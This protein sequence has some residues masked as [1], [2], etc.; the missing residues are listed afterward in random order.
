[1]ATLS[2]LVEESAAK[3]AQESIQGRR[4]TET[5]LLGTAPSPCGWLSQVPRLWPCSPAGAHP[6]H[7]RGPRPIGAQ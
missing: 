6:A 7:L 1:M 4:H 5:R 2:Y 3:T